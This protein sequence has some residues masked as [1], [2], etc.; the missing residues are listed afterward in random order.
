MPQSKPVIDTETGEIYDQRQA[1]RLRYASNFWDRDR[2]NRIRARKAANTRYLNKSARNRRQ[3]L[4]ELA[5]M[6]GAV[7]VAFIV[8]WLT[9]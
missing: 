2:R 9:K 6:A 1:A 4:T 5:L 8:Y 3:H 7:L